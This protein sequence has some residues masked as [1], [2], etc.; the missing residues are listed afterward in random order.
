MSTPEKSNVQQFWE[1]G[2]CG[3]HLYLDGFSRDDYLEHSRIRYELEPEILA[4]GDFERYSGKVTL[5]IGVG[6]GADHQRLAE[7]GAILTGVDL[8]ER[9]V[10]HC[11]RRFEQLGLK[12]RLLTADAENLPFDDCSFDAVYSWGV[13]HH[14]PDTPKAIQ[15]VYRV[16]KP[17]GFA[18]IM[19]YHK[20]SIV[21][22]MLWSRYALLRG[23]PFLSLDSIYS[24]YLESPGTKAYSINEARSLFSRFDV[25]GIE[26]NLTH[27]DLLTSEA[28]QRHR[29]QLLKFAKAIWPRSFIKRF[30]KGHGLQL[31]IEVEKPK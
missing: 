28:G 31:M 18:K 27:A 3:E 2:S 24:D 6:L 10:S 19:I 11:Q 16:L 12:S 21:G 26:T 9:A 14:S 13:L 5:E 23:R 4:F 25:K 15:E 22:Y 29:G 1:S 17:G 8:T 7:S 30:L 20:Y